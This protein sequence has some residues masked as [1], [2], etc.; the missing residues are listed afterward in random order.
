MGVLLPFIETSRSEWSYVPL[1]RIRIDF[2]SLAVSHSRTRVY[3][4]QY[5]KI[6][7]IS[8]WCSMLQRRPGCRLS[9]NNQCYYIAAVFIVPF[10]STEF[11]LHAAC[12]GIVRTI[13]M[14]RIYRDQ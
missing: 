13:L 9:G 8:L 3:V 1:L 14:C 5:G 4:F 11:S 12:N 2:V 10:L 6:P 7:V